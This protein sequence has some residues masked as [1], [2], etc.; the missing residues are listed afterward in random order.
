MCI[1]PAVVLDIVLCFSL[2]WNELGL[3]SPAQECQVCSMHI[4][5]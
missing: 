4:S 5:E 2:V 3:F 1:A